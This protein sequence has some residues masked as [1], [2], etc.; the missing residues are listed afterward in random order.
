ME[1]KS[2]TLQRILEFIRHNQYIIIAIIIAILLVGTSTCKYNQG[3]RRGAE[4]TTWEKDQEIIQY[5]DKYDNMHTEVA[6]LEGTISEIKIAYEKEL[7]AKALEL[8]IKP[9]FIKGINTIKT[10]QQINLDSLIKAHTTIVTDTIQGEVVYTIK[11]DTIPVVVYDSISITQYSK[12]IGWFGLK[13]KA[14][15]DVTA[16][17]GT[18]RV[19]VIKGFQIKEKTTNLNIGPIVGVSYDGIKFRPIFGFGFQYKLIGFHV[20]KR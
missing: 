14:M 2:T 12:N 3:L 19:D 17:G 7:V 11:T 4:L 6:L 18:G 10:S 8:S 9:K 1:Q 20:G 16:N 13:R 5:K 15:L